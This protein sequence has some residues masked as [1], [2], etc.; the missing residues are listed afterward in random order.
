MVGVTFDI[1][2]PE[3]YRATDGADCGQW[4][5]EETGLC[6]GLYRFRHPT[7]RERPRAARHDHDVFRL[8]VRPDGPDAVGYSPRQTKDRDYA[9]EM[10]SE[11]LDAHADGR[12]PE[13]EEMIPHV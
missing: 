11:W 5:H 8:V 6:V 2:A 10:A 9:P 7:Q 12:A 4:I 3:G 1:D 13:V